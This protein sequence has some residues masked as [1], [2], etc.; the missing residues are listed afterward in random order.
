QA[1]KYRVPR[2]VYVNKMDRTGADFY[3]SVEMIKS[4][5]GATPVTVQLP[6]G[7]E[8]GFR[9]VL[10]LVDEVALVWPEDGQGQTFERLPIPADQL[11]LVK[12]H[13]EHMLAALSEVDE[14][15]MEKYLGDEKITR[16]EVQAAIRTGTLA[17][18]IVP[19]FCG[20]SFKNK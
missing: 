18:K 13:R 7:M 1:D 17:M 11:A 8:D 2:I 9:G 4:R 6:L 5:L 15:L 16:A 19:V 10:D 12:E 20:A 3:R 14:R